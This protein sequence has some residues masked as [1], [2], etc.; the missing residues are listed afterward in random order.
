MATLLITCTR[1]ANG[2]HGHNC[3]ALGARTHYLV[4]FPAAPLRL[5]HTH[6]LPSW[7]V[8]LRLLATPHITTRPSQSW[9]S[10]RSEPQASPNTI[11]HN[12]PSE[13]QRVQ[14]GSDGEQAGRG[15]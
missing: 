8:P 11:F 12:A 4:Q 2:F 13:I 3:A 1:Q 10:L 5:P 9:L 15:R 14:E 6:Y 7:S